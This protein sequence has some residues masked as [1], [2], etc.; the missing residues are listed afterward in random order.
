MD[1]VA[2]GRR[3]HLGVLVRRHGSALLTF[4]VRLVGN[5]HRGEELFQEAFLAVWMNRRR[6][7]YPRPFRPWLF[8]IA[9]NEARTAARRIGAERPSTE[10]IDRADAGPTPPDALESSETAAM[11][12]DALA[13]LSNLQREVVVMRVYNGMGYAEI[14]EAI[15]RTEGTARSHMHHA[16]AA[17]RR[18][19]EPRMNDG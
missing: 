2:K 17:L 5:R 19:L 12:T 15:G 14:G 8:A 13:Q 16:L 9:A 11:M 1:Q 3:Q 6:Y 4:L 18:Y 10:T 7:Q